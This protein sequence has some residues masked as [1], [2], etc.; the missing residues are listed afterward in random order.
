MTI[1]APIGARQRARAIRAEHHGAGVFGGELADS[2]SGCHIPQNQTALN[3]VLCH[4]GGT[5]E[6]L[7]A[8]RADGYAER[9]AGDL[10]VEAADFLTCGHV[11]QDNAA[12]RVRFAHEVAGG[13]EGVFPIRAE[14]DIEYGGAITD[15]ELVDLCPCGQVP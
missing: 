5:R 10:T 3:A 2:L 14:R 12:R 8:I 7:A 15:V 4:A 1:A 6:H 9:P 11:P 13:Q